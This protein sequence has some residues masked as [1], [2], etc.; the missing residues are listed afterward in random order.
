MPRNWA[1]FRPFTLPVIAVRVSDTT[2]RALA[3][4]GAS[5][6]LIDPGLVHQLGLAAVGM[7]QIVGLGTT[8]FPV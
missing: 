4:T 7:Q 8:P 3:D 5:Q 1:S 2:V 6:S